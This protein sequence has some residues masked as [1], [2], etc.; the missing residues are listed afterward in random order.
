MDVKIEDAI[1]NI[2]IGGPTMIRSAAKN[3]A[4]VTVV[5]D[6]DDYD[7]IIAEIEKDGTISFETRKEMAVKAFCHTADYDTAISEY[8]SKNYGY[9]KSNL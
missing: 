8:L 1:E 7:R 3:H 9:Q 4:Y 5:V 6:P 2:D